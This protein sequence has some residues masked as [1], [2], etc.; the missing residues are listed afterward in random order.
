MTNR[1]K[2]Y[3]AISPEALARVPVV[4]MQ[5]VHHMRRGA[6]NRQW[7]TRRLRVHRIV[8]CRRP[9]F[10]A[11]VNDPAML[12]SATRR[13]FEIARNPNDKVMANGRT[14]PGWA[15]AE[16][17]ARATRYQSRSPRWF[18]NRK[19]REERSPPANR[20]HDLPGDSDLAGPQ[21]LHT[22]QQTV[23]VTFRPKPTRR[24]A[25]LAVV[26]KAKSQEGGNVLPEFGSWGGAPTQSEG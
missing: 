23:A 17:G 24:K 15:G 19:E 2:S 10:P 9:Q 26:K 8:S 22:P 4:L 6:S 13:V 5:E 16:R 3:V 12:A 14:R 25:L 18:S 21:W 20:Q 11:M 1:P 7:Q